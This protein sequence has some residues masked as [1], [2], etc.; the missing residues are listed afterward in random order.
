MLQMNL[1]LHKGKV[2][3]IIADNIADITVSNDGSWQIRGHSSLN[4]MVL[5][6]NS[7]SQ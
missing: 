1:F 7:S 3:K 4:E 5:L 2:M 6:G